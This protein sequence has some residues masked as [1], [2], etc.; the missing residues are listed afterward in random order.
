MIPQIGLPT[1]VGRVPVFELGVSPPGTGHG[2][3]ADPR[4]R[5]GTVQSGLPWGPGVWTFYKLYVCHEK[6][7]A[8]L[9]TATRNETIE[10]DDKA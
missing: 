9:A 2:R 3:T 10:R 7:M 1:V 5:E 6:P 4:D 8:V